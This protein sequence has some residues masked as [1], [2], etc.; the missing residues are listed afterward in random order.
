MDL[1]AR[2]RV[3][4]FPVPG[5][6]SPPGTGQ[7]PVLPIGMAAAA[8][9]FRFRVKFLLANGAVFADFMPN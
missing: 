9:D 4:A 6:G 7:W 2:K 8:L 3:G 1:D 5:G